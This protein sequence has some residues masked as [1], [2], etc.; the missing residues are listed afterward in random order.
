MPTP[1]KKTGS[2]TFVV[3]AFKLSKGAELDAMSMLV[4]DPNQRKKGSSL[5]DKARKTIEFSVGFYIGGHK[6]IDAPIR[7]S[8]YRVSLEPIIKTAKILT[9]NLGQLPDG[10]KAA[11]L[12]TDYKADVTLLGGELSKILL[13]ADS[14]LSAPP[15]GASRGPPRKAARQKL[16]GD[17]RKVFEQYR[18]RESIEIGPGKSESGNKSKGFIKKLS[19]L[20]EREVQFISIVLNDAKIP[21]PDNLRN[22]FLNP[23]PD[24]ALHKERS[25]VLEKIAARKRKK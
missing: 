21:I 7:P 18:V 9:K 8:D 10:I 19:S 5:L 12:A 4:P 1:N 2:T 24:V 13:A 20:E 22:L 11:L 25:K 17:L 23:G 6:L 3:P 15:R 16:I 14:L